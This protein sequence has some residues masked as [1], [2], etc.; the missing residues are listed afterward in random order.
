MTTHGIELERSEYSLTL[1]ALTARDS[2][3]WNTLRPTPRHAANELFIRLRA[4]TYGRG[5]GPLLYTQEN[6]VPGMFDLGV[7][8][9]KF[10]PG[11]KLMVA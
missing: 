5:R 11:T 2:V 7:T 10:R 3:V 9:F 1:A 4:I 8:G 6:L